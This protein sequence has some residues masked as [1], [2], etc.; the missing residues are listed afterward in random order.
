M[1]PNG[2]FILCATDFS[3]H[4]VA[5]ATVAGKLALR[6]AE[7]LRL[8]HVIDATS[9]GALST[10]AGAKNRRTASMTTH[11]ATPPS[12]RAFTKAA[13]ISRRYNPNVWECVVAPCRASKREASWMAASAMPSPSTSVNMWPA[14]ESSET[15]EPVKSEPFRRRDGVSVRPGASGVRSPAPW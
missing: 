8:V 4:A 9:I 14:S 12:S 10:S 6:R 15:V 5:A 1:N 11:T 13:R 7:N 2:P 3:E